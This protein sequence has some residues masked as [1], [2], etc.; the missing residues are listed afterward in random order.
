VQKEFIRS[1]DVDFETFFEIIET[2]AGMA[3]GEL[4]LRVHEQYDAFSMVF[5]VGMLYNVHLRHFLCCQASV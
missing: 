3:E 4:L 2:M 1:E 5:V